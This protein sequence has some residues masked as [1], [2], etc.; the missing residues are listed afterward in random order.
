MKIRPVQEQDL[1]T[2]HSIEL[3][4]FPPQEDASDKT[5]PYRLAHFPKYFFA[6]EDK[7]QIVGFLSGRPVDIGD[8]TGI[9]DEMYEN[10]PFPVGTTFALLSVNTS[11]QFQG[12]G[13][14]SALITHAIEEA[15]GLGC[16]RMI[17][18][19]KEEKIT[20]YRQFGFRPAGRS[21][22][23]HGG[24]VWYDMYTEL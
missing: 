16:K 1:K 5:F 3:L 21:A 9:T 10:L 15:K 7:G 19:C 14:A 22:S 18:A 13:F 11:P 24:A 4:T 23:D 2:L 6:A 8:S 12:R 20:F 17:L